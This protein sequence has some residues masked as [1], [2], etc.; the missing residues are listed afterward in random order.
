MTRLK[1]SFAALALALALAGFGTVAVNQSAEG[2]SSARVCGTCDGGTSQGG[3]GG[4]IRGCGANA[5][6]GIK[7]C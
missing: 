3:G 4:G 6:G 5:S 1:P 2:T 7:V